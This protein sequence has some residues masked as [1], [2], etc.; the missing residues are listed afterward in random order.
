LTSKLLFGTMS[1]NQPMTGSGRDDF[2]ASSE[3]ITMARFIAAHLQRIIYASCIA[4][5]LWLTPN[6]HCEVHLELRPQASI[7]NPGQSV[8][9]ALIAIADSAFGQSISAAQVILHWDVAYMQLSGHSTAGAPPFL[10]SNFIA[11]PYGLN[12]SLTDGDGMWFGYAPLGQPFTVT[13]QG[14]LLTTFLFQAGNAAG[15]TTI[16]LPRFAGNP[17]GETTVFDGTVP[18]LN[19]TGN[20]MQLKSNL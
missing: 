11:E 5:M 3:R 1:L 17:V 18:N 7:L 14:T 20:L 12:A 13:Q 19:I 16:A 6:A 15:T 2:Y 10:V 4:F 9:V 8:Q